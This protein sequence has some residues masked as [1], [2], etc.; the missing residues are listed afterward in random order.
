MKEITTASRIMKSLA[1]LSLLWTLAFAED[2]KAETGYYNDAL[3]YASSC[4]SDLTSI[5]SEVLYQGRYASYLSSLCVEW[6]CPET[7]FSQLPFQAQILFAQSTCANIQAVYL[8]PTCPTFH[9][10]NDSG[11]EFG[12]YLGTARPVM[13]YT[14]DQV[15]YLCKD[16]YNTLLNN[17]FI[18]GKY[19]SF[20]G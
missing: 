16:S 15:Y 5:E 8:A 4:S 1:L 9:S 7:G 18:R 11:S 10:A 20:I 3:D 12:I 6:G 13:E 17:G 19:L 2:I 14:K